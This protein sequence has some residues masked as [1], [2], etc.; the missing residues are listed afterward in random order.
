MPHPVASDPLAAL[1]SRPGQGRPGQAGKAESV[2]AMFAEA[3]SARLR[4]AQPDEASPASA[5]SALAEGE[6]DA[7]QTEL[8]G[9][10]GV[11]SAGL[12]LVDG[13]G[14]A[15]EAMLAHMQG[16]APKEL[17]PHGAASK[18]LTSQQ[19]ASID[20]PA[21]H[22]TPL[23]SAGDKRKSEASA[24]EAEAVPV[25][26]GQTVIGPAMERR[27]A[28]V[29]RSLG[30]GHAATDRDE[31]AMVLPRG[32]LP[33]ALAVSAQQASAKPEA[34][35][36]V[37]PRGLGAGL[38]GLAL[39]H[40]PG[41]ALGRAAGSESGEAGPTRTGGVPLASL[42]GET[43]RAGRGRILPAGAA[44]VAAGGAARR[45]SGE[46]GRGLT[47][48]FEAGVGPQSTAESL[49]TPLAERAALGEWARS[50]MP[51]DRIPGLPPGADPSSVL[52]GANARLMPG[53]GTLTGRATATLATPFGQPQWG[54]ELGEKLVW[55]AG[56]QGHVA[57]LQLSPPSLG[58]LEV[59]LSV[60]GNEAGAQF[61]SANAAVR[62]AIEAALPRL[63]EMLASSG[64]TLGGASVSS[65]SFQSGASFAQDG[66]GR[67]NRDDKDPAPF[68][69]R[70]IAPPP[71]RVAS[72]LV[73]LYA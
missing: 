72:G 17:V 54:S 56:R 51:L 21:L 30:A 52:A 70:E 36:P 11:D 45:A 65:E 16:A 19:V 62:E 35:D 50:P 3:L 44:E 23:S 53:E 40:L 71:R 46:T 14:D 68:G 26:A 25:K 10:V 5:R 42:S 15:V 7:G 28:E 8:A 64:L 34:L 49:L 41:R 58:S 67:G 43:P 31:S 4:G 47:A 63:R 18:K 48:Q 39:G 55:L 33:A 22:V 2:L 6:T 1:H 73:D 69:E 32:G 27:L 24:D 20:E 59:R 29:V 37:S 57:E 12:L 66:Q 38:P 60:N 61:Y 13:G 9:G